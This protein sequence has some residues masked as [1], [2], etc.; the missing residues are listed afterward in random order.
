[1]NRERESNGAAYEAPE[2][3]QTLR[4]EGIIKHVYPE[5]L[6][7]RIAYYVNFGSRRLGVVFDEDELIPVSN[8][9]F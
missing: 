5:T 8:L 9:K 3:V 4:G 7:D 1:M 2:R 6:R